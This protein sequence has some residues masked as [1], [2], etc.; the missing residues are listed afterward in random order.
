[1]SP[2][3]LQHVSPTE[4]QADGQT[5]AGGGVVDGGGVPQVPAA[6]ADCKQHVPPDAI[7]GG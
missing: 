5:P 3:E 7:K 4:F 6:M 2:V 1:M